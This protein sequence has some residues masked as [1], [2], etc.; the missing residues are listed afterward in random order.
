M[1]KISPDPVNEARA[2]Q[3]HLLAL[4]GEDDP[5]SVQERTEAAVRSVLKDAGSDLR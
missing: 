4:L 5:A 2:Y 3:Q 1:A